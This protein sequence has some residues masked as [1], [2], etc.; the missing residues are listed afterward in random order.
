LVEELRMVAHFAELNHQ[1]DE[2][3]GREERIATAHLTNKSAPRRKEKGVD[4]K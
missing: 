4:V 1:V 3:F 2:V